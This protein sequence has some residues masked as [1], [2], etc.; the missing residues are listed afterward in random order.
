MVSGN[1]S[2]NLRAVKSRHEMNY[3]AD[4]SLIYLVSKNWATT[5]FAISLFL[6]ADS[7]NFSPSQPE[8]ISASVWNKMHHIILISFPRHQTYVQ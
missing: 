8:V 6:L 1:N 5:I 7:K 4:E 2:H 3:N